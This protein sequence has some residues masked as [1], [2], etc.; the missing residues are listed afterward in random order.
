MPKG[1]TVP[2][3]RAWPWVVAIVTGVLGAT[4]GLGL[5]GTY[6]WTAI[7][8]RIGEPDQSLLFWYLPIL[9]VGV[10]GL[11]LGAAAAALGSNRLRHLKQAR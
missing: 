3:R 2:Q 5:I 6:L 8:E 4:C 9:F 11:G 1:E 7:I 10:M